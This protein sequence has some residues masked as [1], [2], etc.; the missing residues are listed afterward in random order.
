VA[1][2]RTAGRR[3]ALVVATSTGGIGQ[4]VRS[5]AARLVA[6][7]WDTCVHAPRATEDLFRFTAVGA[8]FAPVEI[9]AGPRPVTDA[10]AVAELRRLTRTADVVHAHGLRAGLVAVLA[11]AGRPI[12]LV[13]T[14]HNLVMGR[15]GLAAAA[16]TQL[17]RLVAR[18]ADITLGASED[19]VARALL[20]GG[21]DV[22]LG[23]VAAAPPRLPARVP[24]AV[25][26]ELG[27]DG[28]PLVL[29]VGRLHPQ[30]GYDVLVAA[31]ARW[32]RRQ[33]PPLVLV[34]GT[35]PSEAQVRADVART[36]APVRL[37]GH[38]E[39]VAELMA[40]ADV[41]VLPSRWEA[42]SLVAQEALHAGR[43]L[44]ATAVGGLPGLLGDGAA[45]VPP[46]DVDALDRAVTELLDDPARAAELGA[47]GRER[48][49][50]WPTEDDT[51]AQ[52]A[53]VYAELLGADVTA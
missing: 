27:A 51:A 7:S 3:V 44:V 37:L 36:G 45:L 46:G 50:T 13:V 12:P 20:L 34:A 23:P 26:E 39:D 2:G 28:R 47:R 41:V 9:A 15:T 5:L 21:R 38:R 32:A 1:D 10:R 16:Y 19:L 29:A 11:R 49:R 43:P 22:R 4:H 52:V 48:A 31:A 53:A 25:R 30:K 17:E 14:W 6:E 35:G 24:L 33:P 8:R 18:G 40:A 42:R